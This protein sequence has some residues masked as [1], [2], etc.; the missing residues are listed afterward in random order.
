MLLQPD[1]KEDEK[2]AAPHFLY[3]KFSHSTPTVSPCDR[4]DCPTEATNDGLER[5]FYRQVKVGSDE[6]AASINHLAAYG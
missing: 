6:R 4:D 3:L 5:Q 1:V 2:I